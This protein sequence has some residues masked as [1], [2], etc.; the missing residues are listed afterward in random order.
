MLI[1]DTDDWENDTTPP[2]EEFKQVSRSDFELPDF[3][4]ELKD[5]SSP[6]QVRV[7]TNFEEDVNIMHNR[8]A[9]RGDEMQPPIKTEM[10][11]NIQGESALEHFSINALCGLTL[12]VRRFIEV[13]TAIFLFTIHCNS[14]I[15]VE[16]C[17]F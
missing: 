5:L 2:W 7:G 14:L 6:E 3:S 4:T 16:Y 12:N 8:L 9:I 11:R 13:K 17:C 15:S 10:V 1:L